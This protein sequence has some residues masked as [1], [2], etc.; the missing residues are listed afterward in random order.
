MQFTQNIDC[1]E[2][3]AGL[4]GH[5][6]V[7]AHGSFASHAC[8]DC[9]AEYAD[10]LMKKAVDASD[11]PLCTECM[12]LVKP[13]IVFFGE[14]LPSD[15][16]LNR[17]MPAGADLCIVMGTSLTVQPFASLPS[18][19]REETP[20]VL[21]NLERVGGIGSRP[22][23]VVILGEC[24]DGVRKLADALGWLEELEALW[25]QTSPEEV[26]PREKKEE[27]EK[28]KDEILQEEVERLTEEVEA[29][30][31]ISQAHEE[32]TR[33]QLGTPSEKQETEE[34]AVGKPKQPEEVKPEPERPTEGADK[35]DDA[36]STEK[37]NQTEEESLS[38][39]SR[40]AEAAKKAAS[41]L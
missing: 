31:N 7:E 10:E 33:S 22:D 40:D 16:F 26:K 12:G 20:R 6:V 11:V 38:P 5:M 32:R 39:E 24:D 37:D 19:C 27:K 8:I 13:N 34:D 25:A 41:T 36:P 35:K 9:K 29:T 21:I 4:P 14:A 3:E 30:L 17:S 1:L 15:F 23:D 28:N 2:R 18:L